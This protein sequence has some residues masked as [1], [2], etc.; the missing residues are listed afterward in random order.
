MSTNNRM[1]APIQFTE[2]SPE[3]LCALRLPVRKY[4]DH[5]NTGLVQY[6]NGRFVSLIQMVGFLNGYSFRSSFQMVHLPRPFL[7]KKVSFI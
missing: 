5:L 7:Y 1:V 4:T 3:R 6:S 2:N